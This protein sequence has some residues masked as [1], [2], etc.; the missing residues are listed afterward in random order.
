MALVGQ[1]KLHPHIDQVL[2]L[3]RSAE[4][5]NAIADRSVRGRVVLQVR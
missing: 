3:E 2:P 1:G 4:A 5:M